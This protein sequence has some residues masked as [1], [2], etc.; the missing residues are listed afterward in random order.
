MYEKLLIPGTTNQLDN[1]SKEE[2]GTVEGEADGFP[3]MPQQPIQHLE[4]L[5]I[6]VKLKRKT[7]HK[8]GMK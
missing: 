1:R 3:V 2:E 5:Q 7:D 8:N 6:L 4:P